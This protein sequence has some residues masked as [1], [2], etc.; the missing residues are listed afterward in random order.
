MAYERY[1]RNHLNLEAVFSPETLKEIPQPQLFEDV[2]DEKLQAVIEKQKELQKE[3]E[4]LKES[5]DQTMKEH[6]LKSTQEWKQIHA[7]RE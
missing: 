5:H 3:I 4:E 2:S 7:L 6:K 1:R